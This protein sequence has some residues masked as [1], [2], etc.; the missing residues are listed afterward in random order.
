MLSRSFFRAGHTPTLFSAFLYFD[1]SFMTWVLLGPLGVAISKSFGLTPAQK[2]FMVAVPVLSGA[3]L[4]L[5]AGRMV[6]Q[7]AR[8]QPQD[9]A[10]QHR[11]G[12]HEA[13][14]GRRQAE[15]LGDRHP[16]RSQEH[17]G[18]EGQVEIEEGGEQSRG[19]SRLQE[20]AI[21]HG[22]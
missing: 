5:V 3:V 11:Y 1:L 6:D 16:Q 15:R 14:L 12:H 10:G 13:L 8:D 21:D 18:H 19:V 9:R 17:P 22:K 20:G 2:G 4:R 7:Q